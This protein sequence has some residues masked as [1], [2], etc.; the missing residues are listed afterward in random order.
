MEG[1][2]R[3]EVRVGVKR[4][5]SGAGCQLRGTRGAVNEKEKTGRRGAVN[6]KKKKK[7]RR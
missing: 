6:E 7:K 3:V 2:T 1:R 4:R 5:R